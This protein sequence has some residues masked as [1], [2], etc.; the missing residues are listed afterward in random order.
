LVVFH[1]SSSVCLQVHF[2]AQAVWQSHCR[3]SGH[4]VSARAQRDGGGGRPPY[5]VRERRMREEE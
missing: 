5:G 1:L 2:G 4:A 3:F